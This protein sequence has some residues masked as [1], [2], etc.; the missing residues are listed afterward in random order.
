LLV[1]ALTIAPL[2]GV[3][4][5][6]DHGNNAGG[7]ERSHEVRNNDH[8]NVT[9]DNDN[10][11]VPN[12]V[13][14]G[15]DNRHPSGK[16]R[17]V[18][19]GGSG[20]QGNSPSDPDG[21]SNGGADKPGG[22]GGIDKLDQDGNNGC[23]NDDDFEDDNNGRCLGQKKKL[24]EE[25]ATNAVVG[26]KLTVLHLEV[27]RLE[28]VRL[29]TVRRAIVH[30]VAWSFNRR[31]WSRTST[32]SV[33]KSSASAPVLAAP[34]APS[35]D[36]AVLSAANSAK[37]TAGTAGEE[38]VVGSAVGSMGSGLGGG[39]GWLPLTGADIARLVMAGLA[40][41]VGGR[42]ATRAV[43]RRRGLASDEIIGPAPELA[44]GGN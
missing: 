6:S 38:V 3:R 10:D 7:S 43:R 11:G 9:E 18:E 4:A 25:I 29:E 21:M 23:G 31:T 28:I 5:K 42:M 12:N 2:V 27:A 1:A 14:D 44:G 35:G 36:T 30:R 32:G 34:V 33:E 41:I 26:G 22:T 19:P 8:S 24:S 17:S 20:N 16:D 13:P 40:S 37:G 15:G 39:S